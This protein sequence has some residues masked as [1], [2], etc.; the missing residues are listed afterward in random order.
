MA[1]V[2]KKVLGRRRRGALLIFLIILALCIILPV[3]CS[4]CNKEETIDEAEGA[5]TLDETDTTEIKPNENILSSQDENNI[6]TTIAVVEAEEATADPSPYI[7][8]AVDP[9]LQNP[10]LP[11]GCEITSL[12]MCLNYLGYSVDKLT[13]ADN[14]LICANFGDAT[15]GE[16]F[17]GSPYNASSYGCYAPVIAQ[18]ARNFIEA[19]G[20]SQVVTDITGSDFDVLLNYVAKGVPVIVWVTI[21]MTSN[22]EERS[23]YV[24]DEG[25]EAVFLVNEHCVLLCGYDR[26]A[27]TVTVCD[28]LV[29]RTTYDRSIFEDRYELMYR[30]AVV[31]E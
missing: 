20:G 19:Q 1:K 28:P 25:K 30:Q 21:G 16:A 27:G 13:M 10:E 2:S 14:W 9:I 26:N 15:F 31:I 24:T 12:T 6:T 5:I 29:G 3:R 18:T 7:S 4:Q 11:T 22:V 23:L 17:I 8:L